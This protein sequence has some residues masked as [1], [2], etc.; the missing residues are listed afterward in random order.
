MMPD[1]DIASEPDEVDRG[2]QDMQ[3]AEVHK[4]GTAVDRKPTELQWVDMDI[5]RAK[6]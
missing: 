3:K 4:T 2:S 1:T 5:P 6:V